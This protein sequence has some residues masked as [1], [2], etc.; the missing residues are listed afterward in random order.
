MSRTGHLHYL[1]L[2]QF[3]V[4][5]LRIK[6]I[7]DYKFIVFFIIL[8]FFVATSHSA[9]TRFMGAMACLLLLSL[10]QLSADWLTFDP[11]TLNFGDSRVTIVCSS[12]MLV[13][14]GGVDNCW[15]TPRIVECGQCTWTDRRLFRVFHWR[16]SWQHSTGPLST[17]SVS[18]S[19]ASS[20]QSSSPLTGRELT[21]KFC[22]SSSTAARS[23]IP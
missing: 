21:Y 12:S 3:S 5:E 13:T 20:C 4:D 2:S 11:L 9:D 14:R 7:S 23:F 1:C 15:S 6:S 18:M 16:Q 17:T 22:R 8:I 19:R 10:S